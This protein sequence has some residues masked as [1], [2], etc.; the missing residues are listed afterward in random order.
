MIQSTDGMSRPRAATSVHTK[1]PLHNEAVSI[2]MLVP[3]DRSGVVSDGAYLEAL[4]NSK[5]VLVRLFCFWRPYS[6]QSE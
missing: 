4:Q 6:Q 1:M 2:N 5:N 3:C